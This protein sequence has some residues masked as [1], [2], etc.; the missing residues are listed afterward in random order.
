MREYGQ[1]QTAF[2]SS[3]DIRG[4][5]VEAKLLALY[6]LTGPHSNGIGCVF[7]PEQYI[8]A[9]LNWTPELVASRMREVTAIGFV[10]QCPLTNF[11]FLPAYL[12]FNRVS[13]AN[14]AKARAGEFARVPKNT[15]FYSEL[16]DSLNR[17]GDHLKPEFKTLLETVSK[18]FRE[19]F[20]NRCV[21]LLPNGMV[22]NTPSYPTPPVVNQE[23]E[24]LGKAGYTAHEATGT[25]G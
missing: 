6:L 7:L 18:P 15:V 16:A 10:K 8:Q 23:G 11:V 13:N 22:N 14:V 9:D 19:G 2:W 1:V 21:N 5:S 25:H 12:K 24:I 20:G 4:L 3:P 17:F